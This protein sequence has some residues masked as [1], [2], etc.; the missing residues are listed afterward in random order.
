MKKKALSFLVIILFS[1]SFCGCDFFTYEGS[2][3]ATT[4]ARTPTTTSTDAVIQVR[5]ISLSSIN[6][7]MSIGQTATLTV[8]FN[9]AN[10]S[11][12]QVVWSSSNSQVVVVNNGAIFAVAVGRATV[13]AV[14]ADGIHRAECSVEVYKPQ[15][16]GYNIFFS[17]IRRNGS[18]STLEGNI[19]YS[20]NAGA[21]EKYEY[22]LYY[23]EIGNLFSF[24]IQD[25]SLPVPISIYLE[26]TSYSTNG[27]ISV[28]RGI[29]GEIGS[30]S[31]SMSGYSSSSIS[32]H[33]QSIRS[34]SKEEISD[35]IDQ[36]IQYF[37]IYLHDMI[38]V[39]FSEFGFSKNR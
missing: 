26:F 38:G 4:T 35:Y 31:K 16:Y 19:H 23:T 1:L 25:N 21:D 14:T 6:K 29:E 2:T 3:S 32:Y 11:N 34:P 8:K 7:Y 9:P 15:G 5:S 37:E 24:V 13:S 39:G 10:A 20:L 28:C 22:S 27:H 33:T 17:Y 30:G 36:I 12:T 18:Q